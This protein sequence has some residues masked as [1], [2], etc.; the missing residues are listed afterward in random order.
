VDSAGADSCG[1]DCGAGSDS[2]AGSVLR[3]DSCTVSG[4]AWVVVLGAVAGGVSGA[5]RA[6]VDRLDGWAAPRLVALAALAF[7][8]PGKACAATS[9]ST[10]VRATL[11]AIIQRL[12][13]ASL[14]R[15]ASRV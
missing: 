5:G 6:R 2:G 10:P 1:A 8:L 4:A 7:A 9:E 3:G 12:M 13:R 15:A 14:R 11:P